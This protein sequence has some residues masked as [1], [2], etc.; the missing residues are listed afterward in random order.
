MANSLKLMVPLNLGGASAFIVEWLVMS[1]VLFLRCC[2]GFPNSPF[3][4][5]LLRFCAKVRLEK[6]VMMPS[7]GR[8]NVSLER[9]QSGRSCS[10]WNKDNAFV[11][12][13]QK[14]K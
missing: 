2:F 13:L 7:V 10:F 4:W 3:L 5:P 12:L 6:G 9:I 1:L 8:W 14:R 11:W